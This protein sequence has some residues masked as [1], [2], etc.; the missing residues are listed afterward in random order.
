M[1][2]NVDVFKFEIA[3]AI[4]TVKSQNKTIIPRQLIEDEIE[5][6]RGKYPKLGT[7][8]DVP[9]KMAISAAINQRPDAKQYGKRPVSWIFSPPSFSQAVSA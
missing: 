8:R 3:N 6:N 5:H 9:L 4:E 1:P 2:R 7:L